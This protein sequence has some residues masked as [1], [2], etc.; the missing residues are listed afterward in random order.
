MSG[1]KYSV[2][3][4]RRMTAERGDNFA[5]N[6]GIEVTYMENGYSKMEMK[7]RP[8]HFNPIGSIHGGCI[9]TLA[10][11]AAGAAIVSL[12]KSCT[13]L[14]AHT[15]FL[16]AA[17]ADKSKI[18]CAEA[19]PVRIGNH[20]A[21]F[22]VLIKDDTQLEIARFTFEFYIMSKLPQAFLERLGQTE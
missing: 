5:S 9:F 6:I 16:N 22:N 19:A 7:L 2:E 21:V 11:T 10:D 13:T 15:V 20:I 12:G 17:M 14:S 8:F 18:L 1:K 4:Y 3:D